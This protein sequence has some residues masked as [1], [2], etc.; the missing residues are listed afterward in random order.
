M[1]E[2]RREYGIPKETIEPLDTFQS[3]LRLV[4]FVQDPV[5]SWLPLMFAVGQWPGAPSDRTSSSLRRYG[6]QQ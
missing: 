1:G 5:M 2:S 4:Q 3:W 6:L